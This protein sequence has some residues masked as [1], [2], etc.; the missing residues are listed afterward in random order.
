MAS[1]A[2]RDPRDT[3]D[4][5]NDTDPKANDPDRNAKMILM[6]L[7]MILIEPISGADQYHVILIATSSISCNVIRGVDWLSDRSHATG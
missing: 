1:S 4:S 3:D 7:I 6:T 2:A 5:E